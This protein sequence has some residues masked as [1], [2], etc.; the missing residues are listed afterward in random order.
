MEY[1]RKEFMEFLENLQIV[2]KEQCIRCLGMKEN[3]IV[4]Y[5]ELK[6]KD[7]EKLDKSMN[8]S[9]EE[10]DG[11][12]ENI[13]LV[14]FRNDEEIVRFEE[15]IEE[16]QEKIVVMEQENENLKDLVELMSQF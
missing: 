15:K 10:A 13:F 5:F 16:L 8:V 7:V 2:E 9:L 4:Y 1:V 3:E 11:E 12:K 14:R 6:D